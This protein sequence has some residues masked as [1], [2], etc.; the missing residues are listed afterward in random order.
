VR[1]MARFFGA[2]QGSSGEGASR[3]GTAKSGLTAH[4][5][6]WSIGVRVYLDVD[7]EGRDRI[8]VYRTGG[9][10]APESI[11]FPVYEATEVKP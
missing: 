3:C 11:G 1:K 8:M 5:Q 7:A 6:G 4:L 9:S 2:I 10:N